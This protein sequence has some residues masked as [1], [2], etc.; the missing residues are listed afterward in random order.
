MSHA[1]YVCAPPPIETLLEE[2]THF[3]YWPHG[4]FE[5]PSLEHQ[6]SQQR[7]LLQQLR[8]VYQL[9][10]IGTTMSEGLVDGLVTETQVERFSH[11]LAI[12]LEHDAAQERLTLYLPLEFLSPISTGSPGVQ[13]ASQRL[14]KAYRKAWEHQLSQHEV[15]ANYVDGDVLEPE[16]RDGDHPRVVKAAHLIPLLLRVG[17][18]TVAE[19]L[20]YHSRAHN[21]LLKQ[22]IH[23]ACVVAAN[24]GLLLA[25]H[26]T[27]AGIQLSNQKTEPATLTEGRARW[28][29]SVAEAKR[30]AAESERLALL[31]VQGAHVSDAV[32]NQNSLA[33]AIESVRIAALQNAAVLARHKDW[34]T[35]AA[36]VT[37][38]P[39]ARDSLTKLAG[40]LHAKK[41]VSDGDL[42]VWG[43]TIPDLGGSFFKNRHRLQPSG[44]TILEACNQISLHPRL[45]KLVY[46]V[47]LIFGSQVKGYGLTEADCDVA[48]FIRPG[49]NRSEQAYLEQEL[50]LIFNDEHFGGKVMLFWI[51]EDREQLQVIDW[52]EPTY[53]DGESSWLHVLFGALWFGEEY[54]IRELYERL[55]VPYFTAPRSLL[56]GKPVYERWLEEM[57]RDSLQYR[58]LHKGFER[59][60]PIESPMNT[61]NGG[62]IGGQ[63]AFYDSQYRRI[64]TELFVRRVWLPQL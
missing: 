31:L 34:L 18:L 56:A 21:P 49:V 44:D 41:L 13:R 33:T 45:S 38:E 39:A 5:H 28:L 27:P 24:L 1:T 22:S 26:I 40:H 47:A 43:V 25:E 59:Y 48:V 10:P 7:T 55:L 2:S 60:F 8:S 16:L 62:L 37:M 3:S 36:T 4:S 57:E 58:L 46:P 23:N 14:Q 52:P 17:H 35:Y 53:S 6:L 15:R 12:Q 9:L 11:A 61:Q 19:V 51:A 29:A 20:G 54:P 30:Q 42:E 64:A 50:A 32:T 63:A